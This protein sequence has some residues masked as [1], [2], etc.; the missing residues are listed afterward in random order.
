MLYILKVYISVMLESSM[1]FFREFSEFNDFFLHNVLELN[2]FLFYQ[3]L[4]NLCM[5][6]TFTHAEW[7]ST[8][9]QKNEK[10]V[11]LYASK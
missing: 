6:V 7:V 1:N 11:A 4:Q 10:P 9:M 2:V 3:K 8:V 5:G